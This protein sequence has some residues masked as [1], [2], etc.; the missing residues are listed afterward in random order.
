MKRLAVLTLAAGWVWGAA[1]ARAADP[2]P[3]PTGF[4]PTSPRVPAPAFKNGVVV[5]VAAT[6]TPSAG[7]VQVAGFRAGPVVQPIRD[8]SRG[9]K[10]WCTDCAPAVPNPLPSA[11]VS[12]AP[13]AGGSCAL[14]AR[15]RDGDCWQCF[16]DWLCFRQSP[17]RLGLTPTPRITPLY[18]YFPCVERPGCASGNCGPG[19]CA[20]G[21]PRLGG[22]VGNGR[23]C[24]TC[25]QPG[26]PVMPGFRLAAP[27]NA[28]PVPVAPPATDA[29]VQQSGFRLPP[30][31]QM[32]R[33]APRP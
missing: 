6:T 31:P 2:L 11:P 20:P 18:T 7:A 29:P 10:V 24:T 21:H 5:P 1:C 4:A 8:W 26:E 14:A 22:L 9:T 17:L 23:A 19:G 13:C 33:P 25:P 16:K 28:A 30:H 15:G 3:L 27:T 12:A 32:A